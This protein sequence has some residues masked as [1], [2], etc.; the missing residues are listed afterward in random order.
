MKLAMICPIQK[1]GSKL[2][3]SNYRPVSILP[4]LSKVL[5]KIVQTRLVTFLEQQKIIFPQQYGFQKN[6]STTITVLDLYTKLMHA[7]R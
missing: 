3:A 7:L 6:K 4:I 2:K 5:A 1:G